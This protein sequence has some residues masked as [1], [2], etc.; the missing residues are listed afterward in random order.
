MG[1]PGSLAEAAWGIF[2]QGSL[3]HVGGVL[4][5]W[6]LTDSNTNGSSIVNLFLRI[7]ECYTNKSFCSAYL[8]PWTYLTTGPMYVVWVLDS[9]SVFP[10]SFIGGYSLIVY[11]GLVIPLLVP[12][13]R[14]DPTR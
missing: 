1:P 10:E 14:P 8:D 12:E 7:F 5:S 2:G 6:A 9:E 11:S 13:N 4:P 3:L